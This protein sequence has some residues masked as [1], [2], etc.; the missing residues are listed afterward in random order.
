MT[1]SPRV[2]EDLLQAARRA[3]EH[4][5]APYSGY[6]VGAA[7]L[8]PDGRIY[9]GT[10]VENASYGLTVCAERVAIFKGI[11]EGVRQIKAIAIVSTASGEAYP[12]GACR[13]VIQEFG[14]SSLLILEHKGGVRRVPLKDLLPHPFRLTRRVDP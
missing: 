6:K 12:C 1:V 8:T 4:S 7:I 2:V 9:S 13:Q 11:S 3:R 14:E 10:N 5:Y